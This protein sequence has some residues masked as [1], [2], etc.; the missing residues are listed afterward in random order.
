MSS[1][2]ERTAHSFVERHG[3]WN[4]E[5]YEAAVKADKWIEEYGLEVVD[6]QTTL[7]Q[8]R[9]AY[10]DGL[11]RYRVALAALQMLTGTL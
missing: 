11:V 2:Q 1:S 5:Q 6:A 7:I 8:A 3:L 10:G 9:N 4:D